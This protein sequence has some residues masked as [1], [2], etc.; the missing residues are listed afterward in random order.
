MPNNTWEEKRKYPR[1]EAKRQAKYRI[2]H[3]QDSDKVSSTVRGWVI[4]ISRGGILLR[5]NELVT[6]SLHISYNDEIEIQNWLAIE[7]DLLPGIP[8]IRVIGKVVWY[9]RSVS[10]TEYAYDVGIEFKDIREEDQETI[11]N[12][13]NRTKN[14]SSHK[15]K[16]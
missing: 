8:P 11:I 12:F 5:V 10:T 4:N 16:T 2:I 6:D 3:G 9:Q 13:V 15:P 7:F 1:A 14:L